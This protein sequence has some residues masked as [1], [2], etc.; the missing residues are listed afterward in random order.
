MEN[1]R[2]LLLDGATGTELE[3]RGAPCSLPLWSASSLIEDPGLVADIHAAYARSGA[4]VLTANTFRTQRRS[5]SRGGMDPDL[6]A[7]LTQKAV[8]LA[9]EGS[10]L[11]P[12]RECF[13]LGSAAPLEDCF[14]PERVP[15]DRALEIEHGE[16]ARHLRNAG[17]DGILVETMNTLREAVAATRAARATGLPT[18]VS[19]TCGARAQL[20]S[21]EPL[22][23]SLATVIR[24]GA[25]AVMVN[26]LP[27]SDVG[28]CLQDLR[29]TQR[30]FGAYPNLGA[31]GGTPDEPRSAPCSPVEL[32]RYAQSWIASGATL[33]GGCCGTTPDHIAALANSRRTK[34]E[35]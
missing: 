20:L 5:L 28:I 18:L 29:N 6:A 19:F 30:P 9:R 8:D 27:A 3:R 16:H 34:F 7:E 35:R 22:A 14:Q 33:V 12:D 1:R 23:A 11:S 10:L 4:Q 21:G 26:C 25:E 24:E 32:G 15:E 17:V 13:V 31:P 2:L